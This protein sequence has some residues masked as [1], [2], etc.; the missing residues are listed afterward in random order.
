[1]GMFEISGNYPKYCC[2]QVARIFCSEVPF[3]VLNYPFHH[4]LPKVE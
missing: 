1:M 4:E 2:C 3:A